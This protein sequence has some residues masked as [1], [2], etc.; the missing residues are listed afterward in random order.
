MPAN[1]SLFATTHWSVVVAAGD[2]ASPDARSAL[3]RLCRAY[4]Y[5]LYAYVRRRG[6]SPHDAQDL[7][8]AF[9]LQL[10]EHGYLARADP[11]KGRFRTFL[12]VALN[13]FLTNQWHRS[14][15]QKRGGDAVVLSWDAISGEDRYGVE[16]FAAENPERLFERRWAIAVVDRAIQ[17]LQE[18]FMNSGRRELFDVL[19]GVLAGEAV[20]EPY[21]AIAARFELT[22]A[23]VK[24]TVM[25]LR[26]RFGDMLRE[27]VAH[28]VADQAEVDDELRHLLRVLAGPDAG[29]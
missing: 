25:R 7:T 21:S 8:Q 19:K 26:R 1:G 2:A 18:E 24:M 5:P 12:L 22:E 3:E 6:R 20:T 17:R 15:A 23:A 9:F 29:A 14:Q 28:T 11:R 27:E 16:P 4:W 13:H 10:L